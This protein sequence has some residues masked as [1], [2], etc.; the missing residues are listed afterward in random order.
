MPASSELSSSIPKHNPVCQALQQEMLGQK[1]SSGHHMELLSFLKCTHVTS[2]PYMCQCSL[3][4]KWVSLFYAVRVVAIL[5]AWNQIRSLQLCIEMQQP[6]Y[7]EASHKKNMS[8]P[9]TKTIPLTLALAKHYRYIALW[10]LGVNVLLLYWVEFIGKRIPHW[11]RFLIWRTSKREGRKQEV[12]AH[13]KMPK[14]SDQDNSIHWR[15]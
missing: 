12:T 6:Q 15:L 14:N 13:R 5:V 1:I 9:L 7:N 11:G 10:F 3:Y 8:V 2:P 4:R